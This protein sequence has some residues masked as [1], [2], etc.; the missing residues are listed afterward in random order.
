MLTSLTTVTAFFPIGQWQ[1][2]GA[3]K[4]TCFEPS[5]FGLCAQM[6]VIFHA[7]SLM[8]VNKCVINLS[9]C[10]TEVLP[11]NS[12]KSE[13]M[14]TLCSGAKSRIRE[15]TGD[16]GW[17]VHMVKSSAGSPARFPSILAAVP[18]ISTGGRSPAEHLLPLVQCQNAAILLLD[19][20]LSPA[21]S[22]LSHIRC[23]SSDE[24]MQA[25]PCWL[26]GCLT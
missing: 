19:T 22:C 12:W 23:P 17:K 26:P 14:F 7:S 6:V 5:G 10:D 16:L 9:Q 25:D 24:E 11:L 15:T 4:L 2:S 1:N 18:Q 8:D 21:A 3:V 13:G 20:D